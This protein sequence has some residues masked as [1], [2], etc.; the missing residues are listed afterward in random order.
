MPRG[1]S[2]EAEEFRKQLEKELN[3]AGR[4]ANAKLQ[5]IKGHYKSQQ[6]FA[7]KEL[8]RRLDAAGFLT[9]KGLVSYSGK[10]KTTEELQYILRAVEN[11]NKS[12]TSTVKGIEDVKAKTKRSLGEIAKNVPDK[13]LT[14]LADIFGEKM[15]DEDKLPGSATVSII[16]WAIDRRKNRDDFISEME[17]QIQFAHDNAIKRDLS[18]IYTKYVKPFISR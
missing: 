3:K 15:V 8:T 17:K 9:E 12:K 2:I 18:K 10:G 7:G 16:D 14:K 5:R 11:F 4:S 13:A 1:K 6:Y